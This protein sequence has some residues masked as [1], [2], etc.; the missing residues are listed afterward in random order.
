MKFGT[1]SFLFFLF[2]VF[3]PQKTH[4][5]TYN[6]LTQK[7]PDLEA[8]AV[9]RL[10]EEPEVLGLV[11]NPVTLKKNDPEFFSTVLFPLP[12]IQEG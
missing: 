10:T 6:I 2:F 11:P 3:F 5:L 9:P 4:A 1:K 8:Q 12:L 7:G